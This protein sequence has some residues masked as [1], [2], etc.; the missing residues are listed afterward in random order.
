MSSKNTVWMMLAIL[1]VVAVGLS[2][3]FASSN[4]FINIVVY[5]SL[6]L[7]ILYALVPAFLIFE[8]HTLTVSRL[9]HKKITISL[10]DIQTLGAASYGI[11]G[12]SQGYIVMLYYRT[13]VDLSKDKGRRIYIGFWD[14]IDITN[15][16]NKIKEKNPNLQVILP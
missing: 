8:D 11:P 4:L 9:L 15:V 6:F 10:I 16:L 2:L 13:S 12:L 14:K 3:L 1:F 5:I 7:F